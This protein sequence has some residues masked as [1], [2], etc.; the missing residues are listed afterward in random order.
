MS[1]PGY[2]GI[3]SM[4]HPAGPNAADTQGLFWFY[5]AVS[6]TVWVLVVAYLAWAVLR[7]RPEV[8]SDDARKRRATRAVT[9]AGV[10]TVVTMFV[11]L[12]SSVATGRS[13]AKQESRGEIHVKLT[14]HQWWW[15][16]TYDDPMPS[17]IVTTANELHI[18]V[19]HPVKIELASHDV[20]HSLWIPSLAG[21]RD[22]IPGRDTYLTLEANQPGTYRGQCAEFCG[23]QHAHMALFVVAE[24]KDRYDA[25]LE[26]QRTP[27]PA[28][29]TPRAQRGQQLFV[30]GS[31]GMCHAVAGT[32]A[33]A[34]NGPNLSHF[35]SRA[36]LGAGVIPNTIGHRAGWLIDPQSVK[37]GTQMPANPMP[38]ED[39]HAVL[40]YLETL[41]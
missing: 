41:R 34:T 13:L 38:P 20:I 12:V 21:K 2:G 17:R 28:P 19:G 11:M 39:L 33:Q 27:P 6:T 22:L 36:S 1:G 24:P 25:W 7:R 5:L 3:Q 31:C 9:T 8:A 14:G 32:D 30:T 15:E 26:A 18:P 16:V 29:S 35:A 23:V 4:L 10:I 37:P 40:A